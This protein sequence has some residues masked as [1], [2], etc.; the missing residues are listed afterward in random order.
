MNTSNF[1]YNHLGVSFDVT[2]T[3]RKDGEEWELEEITMT[4]PTDAADYYT[5]TKEIF[6]RKWAST[7]TQ[8]LAEQ[9]RDMAWDRFEGK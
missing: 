2:A 3:Y 6:V 4:G 9:I 7:E 1:T 8:T 5:E